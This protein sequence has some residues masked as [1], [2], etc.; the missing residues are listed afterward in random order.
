M[1]HKWLK[2]KVLIFV[3]IALFAGFEESVI[4]STKRSS[5][6]P[7]TRDD[8]NPVPN[9]FIVKRSPCLNSGVSG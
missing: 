8:G 6:L 7:L 1:T 4:V 2:K 5:H 3:S 9:C